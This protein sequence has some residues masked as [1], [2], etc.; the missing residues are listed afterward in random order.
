MVIL[1]NR[2]ASDANS[3]SRNTDSWLLEENYHYWELNEPQ[4]HYLR[5]HL[6]VKF[7]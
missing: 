6:N 4:N 3:V 5:Q 2:H 1:G 7:Q